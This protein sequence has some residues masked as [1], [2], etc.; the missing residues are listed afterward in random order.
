[1]R[2]SLVERWLKGNES[3]M[4]APDL[5]CD[6]CGA[7]NS[8]EAAICRACQSP[9]HG[10]PE[11]YEPG[12]REMEQESDVYIQFTLTEN[13]ITT[14]RLSRQPRPEVHLLHGRYEVLGKV[15]TGG[16]GAVY[17]ARDRQRKN[18]LVAIKSI[19][20]DALSASQA[21][22]ATDTY[23]RELSLLSRLDHPHLPS[24][25]EHFADATHWYLVMDFIDGEPLDEYLRQLEEPCLPLEE[26]IDV[27]LQLCD[28]LQYLHQLEPP[29][30]FRDVK[31]ANIMRTPGGRL[32]L[33]DFGI[34]RRFQPGRTRDTAPLGSPG[35]AAP[36]Q[37]GRA[38]STIRTDIYGLGATLYFLLT[39]HDPATT[40][41]NLPP[42]LS[43]CPSLPEPLTEL[44]TAM[45]VH[46]PA[47]RPSIQSVKETLIMYDP[48]VSHGLDRAWQLR[49]STKVASPVSARGQASGRL[50]RISRFL[51]GLFSVLV[52][53]LVARPYLM[54]SN[55]L[56]KKQPWQTSP[57][58]SR[59]IS[60]PLQRAPCSTMQ[61]ALL[62]QM[63]AY[64]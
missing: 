28:V 43:L 12:E 19:E 36:E 50:H 6:I 25:H 42:I 41:F 8:R 34:A 17:K 32:Y 18:R 27:G 7:A 60:A 49:A 63:S 51:K 33:I 26:V 40:P 10:L 55:P 64:N 22:E 44:I 31:P 62:C 58:S 14:M 23:N 3:S 16:F 4:E 56:E 53:Y 39:G 20:L 61:Q 1:L 35:F 9:L 11:S 29:I 48:M 21:I 57:L 30:I 13:S 47:D 52:V 54:N 37:Y 38:Q 2:L 24:L 5:Y 45:L 59:S 15:G 46:D